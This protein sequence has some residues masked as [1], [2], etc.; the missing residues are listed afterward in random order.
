MREGAPLI[1]QAQFFDGRWQGRADFLRRI[2]TPSK[3][4][5]HAYEVLDT[6]LAKQ[7][8]P[9]VVH[10]LS[11]YNRMLA[12]IQGLDPRYIAA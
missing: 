6:K 3:L 5:A 4:G 11:V 7:I 10:Q 1:H 9:T 2:E 12:D 8:K